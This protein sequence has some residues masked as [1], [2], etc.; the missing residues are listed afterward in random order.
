MA[1]AVEVL[2]HREG[3]A[4]GEAEWITIAEYPGRNSRPWWSPDGNLL[5]FL[6]MKDNYPDIWAQ[7]LDPATKR[8]VGDPS[9]IM[10]FH[11]TRKGINIVGAAVFGPAIGKNQITFS[12][13]EQSANIWIAEKQ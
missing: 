11:E 5:Y 8:P 2:R 12:L 3:R 4:A 6:S 1:T 10:H 7:R 13:M 9:P